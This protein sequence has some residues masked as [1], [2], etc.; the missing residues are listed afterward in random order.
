MTIEMN[1]PELERVTFFNG[2]RLTAADLTE[3]QRVLREQRWLHNR[4]LHSW[5][6]GFGLAV[7][8]QK[9]DSKV[10]IAPGYAVDCLGRE[11][12]LTQA[13]TRLVPPV[14]G[15]ESGEPQAYFLIISYPAD[16]ELVTAARRDGVCAPGGAVRLI[17]TPHLGWLAWD[18]L[19]YGF[20]L[21]LAQAWVQNCRL[22][23]PLSFKQRRS[24]RPAPLPY[25]A[26]GRTDPANTV[27]EEVKPG[28][29][30]VG[31]A[32]QVDTSPAHFR[33]TPAYQAHIMGNRR[34]LEDPP[35]WV[36]DGFTHIRWPTPTGFRLEVMLPEGTIQPGGIPLNP[37][38][39]LS[40]ETLRELGWHVVWLG[41]EVS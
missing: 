24:A 11:I 7:S 4:S 6:I 8:G 27:W 12:I 28:D 9:G 31:F 2:Q 39:P 35:D 36:I 20:D 18:K 19:H 21:I 15:D 40:M 38:A 3:A 30:I 22:A 34:K 33:T 13:Q 26:S 25:I 32:T 10:T 29:I 17:E 41:M 16:D 14:A 5:G 37:P 23:R 1:I